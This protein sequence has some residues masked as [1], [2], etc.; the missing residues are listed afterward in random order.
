MAS[1]SGLELAAAVQRYQQHVISHARVFPNHV[2][3]MSILDVSFALP[4]SMPPVVSSCVTGG[5]DQPFVFRTRIREDR[6]SGT[7]L[8]PVEMA[9]R[10][11]LYKANLSLVLEDLSPQLLCPMLFAA[12]FARN[13]LPGMT[14]GPGP[15]PHQL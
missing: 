13:V 11:L 1:P 6:S 8:Y 12:N 14:P 7:V 3:S 2:G 9:A 4:Q 5:F 10:S 15:L